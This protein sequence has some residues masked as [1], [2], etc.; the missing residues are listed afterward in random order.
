[1]STY[2][3]FGPTTGHHLARIRLLRT[4]YNREITEIWAPPQTCVVM[5]ESLE[6]PWE[7]TPQRW[8]AEEYT[9]Q[10]FQVLIKDSQEDKI[11]APS[12]ALQTIIKPL[13][14]DVLKL[15]TFTL[16]F[17]DHLINIPNT[18][19]VRIG[20]EVGFMSTPPTLSYRSS[21][22]LHYAQIELLREE[23]EERLY[24]QMFNAEQESIGGPWIIRG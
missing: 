12:W 6:R 17:D 2:V 24:I 8:S 5:E 14:K 11:L 1:M 21:G 15:G 10:L 3:V 20:E 4:L 16:S 9:D 19:L 13:P 18:L 7:E 23:D 22:G